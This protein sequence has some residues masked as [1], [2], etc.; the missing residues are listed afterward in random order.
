VRTVE[1]AIVGDD[2]YFLSEPYGTAWAWDDLQWSYGAPVS[3]LSFAENS[4]ER[5]ITADPAKPGATVEQW[6]PNLDYYT[7]ENVMTMSPQG[8]VAHR[9]LPGS[10]LVRVGTAPAQ[11]LH[12]PL[13]VEDPAHHRGSIQGCLRATESRS[14]ELSLRR[15]AIQTDGRICGGAR[16]VAQACA[17]RKSQWRHRSQD[18]DFGDLVSVPVAQD[19]MVTNKVA[20]TFTPSCCC[21]CCKA[22]AKDGSPP[23]REWCASF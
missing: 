8:E 4:V 7:L 9:R 14:T 5:G 13:A 11:G 12:A 20:R 17:A 3:A 10:M 2:S 21:A 18:A 23:A 6:T 1:G 15:I 16:P 22:F 19:I